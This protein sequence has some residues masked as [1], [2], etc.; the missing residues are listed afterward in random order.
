VTIR[1]FASE[2][3][4]TEGEADRVRQAHAKYF[5]DLCREVHDGITGTTQ[6]D[7]MRRARADNTNIF[8]ALQ[9]LTTRARTGD[10]E[11]LEQALLIAGCQNW[12]WHI[13]GQHMTARA[14]V[15]E[16]LALAQDG[17]PTLGRSLALATAGMVSVSTGEMSR[18]LRE[19]QAS[20]DDALAIGEDAARAQA[21]VG[22]GFT[23]VVEGRLEEAGAVLEVTVE[24][25]E[26]IGEDF[27]RAVALEFLGT[28]RGVSGDLD[29]GIAMV[30]RALA[31][32]TRIDDYE[33]RGCGTSFLAQLHFMKGDVDR[34]LGQYRD[35]LVLLE[36]VGDRPEIAR[37]HGEMGWAALSVGRIAEARRSFL[38]SLRWYDEVGSARGVGTALT[39][40]AV[41]ED[42]D[43]HPDRA[44]MLAAA[45][46]VMADQAGVV[47]V[48]A[49][50]IGAGDQIE[51]LR[52]TFEPER[53]ASLTEAGR[54]MSPTEITAMIAERPLAAVAP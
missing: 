46:D 2:R 20:W 50:G 6:L 16:V 27:M 47:V 26:R 21:G 33:A 51:A 32:A 38:N 29:G 4:E 39:G 12:V 43:G 53:L 10:A 24:L 7:S 15:D 37:V 48:H 14:A 17:A 49:M 22:I 8:L 13:N 44:V 3:L 41:A 40:L 35:A 52:A 1:E 9:W 25:T 45:A 28:V 31:I 18:G 30:E 42:S 36:T 54:G 5:V 11:A 34:A 19:W 23:H